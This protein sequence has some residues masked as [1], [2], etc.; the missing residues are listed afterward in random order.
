M[1]GR[2]RG[3]TLIAVP[4]N[5]AGVNMAKSLEEVGVQGFKFVC[6]DE[7]ESTRD[8]GLLNMETRCCETNSSPPED[9][10]CWKARAEWERKAYPLR[11]EKSDHYH[12]R[13]S[14]SLNLG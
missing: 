4:T 7:I 8:G 5:K 9:H 10:E 13:E 3:M 11:E 6:S 12:D 1:Q 14:Q 2:G